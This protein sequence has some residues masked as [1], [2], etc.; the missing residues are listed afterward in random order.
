LCNRLQNAK[1]VRS[2]QVP[3]TVLSELGPAAP[4]TPPEQSV[5]VSELRWPRLAALLRRLAIRRP[6]SVRAS[7][8]MRASAS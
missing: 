6:A 1:E 8:G 3:Y 4:A 7:A 5:I 2:L